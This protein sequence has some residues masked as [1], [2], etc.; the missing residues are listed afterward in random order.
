M[1]QF[2]RTTNEEAPSLDDILLTSSH[3]EFIINHPVFAAYE[4]TQ[5]HGYAADGDGYE[6]CEN[7]LADSGDTMMDV[8][9][10]SPETYTQAGDTR[11]QL[12]ARMENVNVQKKDKEVEPCKVCE[13]GKA[14]GNYFGAKVCV[15][16]KVCLF[17]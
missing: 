12:S 16:C 7:Q 5:C 1:D 8:L 14:M 9:D 15:P 17:L 13:E 4:S 10:E 6:N 11:P 3:Q 2:G